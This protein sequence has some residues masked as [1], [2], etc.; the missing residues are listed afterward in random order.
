MKLIFMLGILFLCACQ[1]EKKQIGLRI[2]MN[3][4]PI[5]TDYFPPVNI[6]KPFKF[7]PRKPFKRTLTDLSNQFDL[8]L[9]ILSKPDYKKKMDWLTLRMY[10]LDKDSVCRDT[11]RLPLHWIYNC[12]YTSTDNF[13]SY[14]TK[15]NANKQ[16]VDN[17]FGEIIVADFNFDG[18]E[19]I[20]AMNDSGGNGGPLYTYFIQDSTFQFHVDYYLTNEMTFFPTIIL[21]ER[22]LLINSVHANAYGNNWST[23]K[24][25]PESKKWKHMRS[26]FDG[27]YPE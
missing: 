26:K 7:T 16:V 18:L 24:Y 27:E 2:L 13:R 23:Y 15:V 6:R 9:S 8:V 25:F 20:A 14:C 19:D 17:D 22:K 21:P 1:K 12:H 10:I 3:S 5:V 4:Y 11:L